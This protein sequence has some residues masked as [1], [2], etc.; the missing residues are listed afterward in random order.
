MERLMNPVFFIVFIFSLI[1]TSQTQETDALLH[2]LVDLQVSSV[3]LD[4]VAYNADGTL[5]AIGGR[6]NTIRLWDVAT[7][8]FSQ[9]LQGHSGWITR[10]AFSSDGELLLSASHDDT[11]L[12]WDIETGEIVRTLYHGDDVMGVDFT[13]DDE[14]LVTAG[15]DGLVI[16]Q[17]TD[18]AET[19]AALINAGGAVWDVAASP[20]DNALAVA[21]DDGVIR[22]WS[23][24]SNWMAELIGHNA[25]VATLAYAPDGTRLL[26]SSLDSVLH[27]WDVTNPV[28]VINPTQTMTGHLAPALGVGFDTDGNTAFSSSLD[29][30]LRLWDIAGTVEPSFSLHTLDLGGFPATQLAVSENQLARV[31]TDGWLQTWD[32]SPEALDLVYEAAQPDDIA[33]RL[34]DTDE[35]AGQSESTSSGTTNTNPANSANSANTNPANSTSSS[36]SSASTTS[37]APPNIGGRVLQIPAVNMSVGVTTFYLD[38]TTWAIDPW[39]HLVGHFQGTQ[40]V[41]G[42]GNVVLGG[43]S[44]YPDGSA[45]IF[46]SLYGVNIGDEI[47]L[48]DSGVQRR[49]IVSNVFSVDYTDLSV[50]YPTTHNRLTLVT[51]DIPSYDPN[52]NWYGER[53]VVVAEEAP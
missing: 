3:P 5:L 7:Q 33:Q 17:R 51:C 15:R 9:T 34:P 18:E 27:V 30:T 11:A 13:S 8:E 45:G 39:E 43:H 25:P 32:I 42:A 20:V 50:V 46:K 36:A 2:Q 35:G 29:G 52:S 53:L 47:F 26:S 23:Y 37:S 40:W 48:S 12:L 6:D 14:W 21:G 4:A 31:G 41:T 22:L 44:E 16:V 19:I 10:V 49:Y 38:G 28:G 1:P 24:E